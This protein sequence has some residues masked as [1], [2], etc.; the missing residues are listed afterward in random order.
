M[1]YDEIARL[2]HYVGSVLNELDRQQVAENTFVLF[3]SDN[4]APFPRA[5][6]TVYDSGVR[7]PWIVRFP[8]GLEAGSTTASLVSTVDLAPTLL[9]LAGVESPSSFEGES[10]VPILNDP[11]AVVRDHI[12]AERNWHDFDDR[13]RAV[14]DSR[15]KY[16]RNFYTDIPNGPPADAIRGDTFQKMRALRDEG[17]LTP[18]QHIVFDT[19]RP[20]E[21]LYLVAD[22]PQELYDVSQDPAHAE[23]L[24]RLR[25]VLET[26]QEATGDTSPAARTPDEYHRETGDALPNR[27][28]QRMPPGKENALENP[29]NAV[30]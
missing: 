4:G 13:V 12:F 2:D 18:Q 7:T 20:E 1:Y 22:D 25:G 6:T 14:R 3:I 17:S 9:D 26:W 19:P 29:E 24:E 23:A 27:T 21:E 8:A 11:S 28:F 5:K 15:Y 10:I 30:E 16:I